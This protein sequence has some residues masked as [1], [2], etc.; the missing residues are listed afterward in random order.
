MLAFRDVGLIEGRG[1]ITSHRMLFANRSGVVLDKVLGTI[2]AE[3]IEEF[4]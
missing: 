4:D 1:S 2:E 3:I